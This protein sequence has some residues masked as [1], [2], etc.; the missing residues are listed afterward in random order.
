MTTTDESSAG[1]FP[2]AYGSQTPDDGAAIPAA[3]AG[4]ETPRKGAN[5]DVSAGQSHGADGSASPS[6][7]GGDAAP[8]CGAAPAFMRHH[9]S[10]AI[11]AYC[12]ASDSSALRI[13]SRTARRDHS[14]SAFVISM[15]ALCPL[16]QADARKA[17]RANFRRSE[18]AFIRPGNAHQTPCLRDSR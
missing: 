12:A 14:R 18:T 2:A 9:A 3:R 6:G 15:T 13:S 1:A 7:R 8:A 11:A 4:R 10:L 16:H 17:D 5:R